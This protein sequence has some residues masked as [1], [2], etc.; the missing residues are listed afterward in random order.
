MDKGE[1]LGGV[2]IVVHTLGI[3]LAQKGASY[4]LPRTK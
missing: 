4:S 3:I 2:R 1:L